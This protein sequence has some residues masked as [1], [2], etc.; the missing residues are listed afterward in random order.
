MVL[1]PT[2][3]ASPAYSQTPLLATDAAVDS[4]INQELLSHSHLY[5]VGKTERLIYERVNGLKKPNTIMST[6]Y[7]FSTEGAFPSTPIALYGPSAAD[8]I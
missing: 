5:K 8:S 6:L 1:V 3:G 7:Q 4:F 2:V